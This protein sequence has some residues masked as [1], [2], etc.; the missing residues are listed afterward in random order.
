MS[1]TLS[2]SYL[3]IDCETSGLAEDDLIVAF[4]YVR[5]EGGQVVES[6]TRLFDW[7]GHGHGVDEDWLRARLANVPARRRLTVEQLR[8]DGEDPVAVLSAARDLL[9][10]LPAEAEL[11]G[12]N[13]VEFDLPWLR[14]HFRDWLGD[15]ASWLDNVEVWDTGL[16]R[17]LVAAGMEPYPGE[18]R[19][20]CLQRVAAE[21]V[22]GVCWSLER[23]VAA[24][25]AVLK[26]GLPPRQDPMYA[27]AAARALYERDRVTVA[28]AVQ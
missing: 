11:V 14:R 2:D 28:A 27:V 18:S 24:D 10:G 8:A 15:E 1:S 23:C 12:H 20:Q 3:V 21:P 4:S 22:P 6:G 9:R 16:F 17:K 26:A 13:I 7:L 5:A 25:E 19:R